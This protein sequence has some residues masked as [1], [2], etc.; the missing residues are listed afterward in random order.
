MPTVITLA[1]L[2]KRLRDQGRIASF[3]GDK[4]TANKLYRQ[5]DRFDRF[6]AVK[7]IDRLTA[8]ET[9]REIGQQLPYEPWRPDGAA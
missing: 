9:A 4:L 6:E 5:A 2:G 1:D 7:P 8:V 3:A